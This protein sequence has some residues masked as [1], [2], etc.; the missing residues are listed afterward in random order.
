MRGSQVWMETLT[1]R[2]R[3]HLRELLDRDYARSI[4]GST[5]S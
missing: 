5:V 4:Y 2:V 1:A 3:G